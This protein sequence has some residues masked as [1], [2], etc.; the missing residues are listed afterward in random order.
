M[1]EVS[2]LQQFWLSGQQSLV[3]QTGLQLWLSSVSRIARNA[4]IHR[5][6]TYNILKELTK[7]WFATSIK[8]SVT[9]YYQMMH[10]SMI[11]KSLQEKATQFEKI[12][13]L[14]SSLIHQQNSGFSVQVYEG[15]ESVSRLYLQIPMTSEPIRDLLWAD[16]ID[17]EFK[18]RLY[19]VYLPQRVGKWITNR[20]IVSATAENAVFANTEI[21]PLTEVMMI[22]LPEFVLNCEIILFDTNKILIATMETG[23]IAGMLIESQFLYDS[24]GSIFEV[25]W[26]LYPQY[27]VS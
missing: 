13:P 9:T 27:K 7:K 16:H 12:V 20:A 1:S 15:F 24:L 21:V 19:T 5:V 4:G 18:H 11:F 2:D 22:D 14:L 25:L 6:T 3:Y 17:E 26:R 23:N 8:K 10:P